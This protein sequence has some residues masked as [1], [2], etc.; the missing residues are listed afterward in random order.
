MLNFEAVVLLSDRSCPTW[1][2]CHSPQVKN[3]WSKAYCIPG[4]L[5]H[6][7][8]SGIFKL[9]KN[10]WH[11]E[12]TNVIFGL[13]APKNIKKDQKIKIKKTRP[14]ICCPVISKITKEIKLE[15]L[16]SLRRVERSWTLK[17]RTKTLTL[18]EHY[19]VHLFDVL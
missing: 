1:Q 13:S 11:Y 16:T 2:L 4:K 12:K 5:C 3:H 18:L 8:S 10:R 19:H 7:Q 17:Q 15:V 6:L 9:E 14:K